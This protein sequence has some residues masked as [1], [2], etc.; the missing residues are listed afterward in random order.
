MKN[1]ESFYPL[2]PMQQG[3]IFH[4]LLAPESGMYVEQ[5]S[6][7]LRGCLD[8]PAFERAWQRVIERHSILR[9]GFAGEELKEPVQVVHKRVTLPLEQQ[10]WRGLTAAEQA[11]RLD[12]FLQAGRARGFKL[13]EPPLMRLAL[14]RVADDACDF[15]WCYHHALLDGWSV[16]LLMREVFAFYDAFRRGQDLRLAPPRPY[17]DYIAWLK[18]QDAARAEAFWRRTLAGFTAPT[19]LT[20]DR[21]STGDGGCAEQEIRLPLEATSALQSFARKH[22]L[23]MNTLVQGAWALLLSRYSGEESVVFGATVSGRPAELPGAETMIG[24]F[25]N[26]LPVRVHAPPE[27]PLTAWLKELQAQQFEMRQYEY[28]SLVQIQGWSDVPRNQ[29]LFESILVFE[30]YPISEALSEHTEGLEILNLRSAEQTNFPLALVAGVSG[31]LMLKILYDKSRFEAGAIRRMI[32][33]LQTLLDGM[34]ANLDGQPG[35]LGDVPLLTAAERHQL[36]IEWNDTAAEFPAD[37]CAHQLFESQ[38]ERTPEAVAIVCNGQRLTY[39]ELNRNANQLAHHLQT[40][41][42]KPE[43]LVGICL[44]RSAEMIVAALGVLKAGGAYVP[45]DPAYPLERLAFMLEDSGASILITQQR[46]LERLPP[47]HAQKVFLDEPVSHTNG[48]NPVSNV[49][50]ENLAYVIYTSGSTGQPK[51]ALLQHRG[52]CNLCQVYI[53]DF[54]ITPESRVLQFFSLSFDGSVADSFP[55]LV[56]GA[57]LVIAKQEALL[58]GP[59]LIRLL[60]DQAITVAYLPPAVL[61]AL[62]DDELPSLKTLIS[63]GESCSREIAARWSPG[64]RFFNAYGPTEATVAA[65][66]Y[67]VTETPKDNLVPIGRP[68]AN[69]QLYLLDSRLRPVP[70]GVP[71]ELHVG[72]VGLARGYLNRPEL[73]AEKFIAI[74]ELENSPLLQSFGFAQGK[75]PIL[76]KTGDLARYRPDGNIE[77]LGRMDHQVKIRG[78]RIEPG[79]IEAVLKRH[80][81]LQDAVVVAKESRGEKRLVAYVV[82]KE[83]GGPGIEELRGFLQAKL[84]AYMTPAAFVSLAAL[85]LNP[86]GKVDRKA[87][88]ASDSDRPDLAKTFVAPRDALELQLSRIWEDILGVQPV[89]VTD[90]FFELGGHSLLAV[91]LAA[92]VRQQLGRDLQLMT[93]FQNTTVEQLASAL[94]RDQPGPSSLVEIQPRGAKR[95]LFFIHPSGG[96]VHWYA[97]LARR[98]GKD[99]PFYGL[100]ARGVNGD[101]EIHTRIEEMAACYAA[102]IRAAQPEGPYQ[103]GSW[104]MGVIIAFETAQ[105]IRAEGQEVSLLAMLDQGPFTPGEPPEDGAAYL[106]E[107]FGK[108]VP[109]AVDRLRQME[110]EA[111]VAHV[112]AEAKRVKFVYPDI[113]LEQFSRFVHI[114]KTHTEAWRQ[115]EP[116]SYPGRVTLFRSAEQTEAGDLGWGRFA[117]GGVEIH[118]VAGDHLSMIHEPD[119]RDLAEKLKGCLEAVPA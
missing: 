23:T 17:R 9:T 108:H 4:S 11:A 34:A 51:G 65:S 81:A 44:E 96:S 7:R 115:Y 72:G 80:P 93:L 99:Q 58:P 75:S 85:P 106:A 100:Q 50:P 105:Q 88:P 76:Y 79:E 10:D 38:V 90:D 73:T 92:Q 30:N 101:Q 54:E 62:P 117:L 15:V 19:P 39:A 98:L 78:F 111:Q 61:A 22:Q 86:N 12:S 35:S 103:L 63:A 47:N 25:I 70:V 8:I 37:R 3:M 69:T 24:L 43:T 16:P 114:L 64:R 45:L 94:R 74:R 59:G 82:P 33:H 60:R 32:G 83:E 29:P 71:G 110:P 46:L 112:L 116:Q 95:P 118:E 91:R 87:L 52:L 1:V 13:A 41:G 31:E 28:S 21:A 20:V 18:K 68:I 57:A 48:G 107:V 109:V 36:L 102:A 55:S 89:G 27:A 67:L 2:S 104:S 6:C 53:R 56:A 97:D 113:T 49:S 26:T 84:P 66:H 77:F 14:I 119:V 42:V 40:L 5:V